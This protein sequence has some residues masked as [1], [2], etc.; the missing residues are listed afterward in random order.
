MYKSRMD[1]EQ[2][3]FYNLTLIIKLFFK[4]IPIK[5]TFWD[6]KCFR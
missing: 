5:I 3:L 2:N 6:V 1:N 4:I